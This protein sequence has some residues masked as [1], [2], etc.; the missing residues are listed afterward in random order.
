[1]TW[2]TR[3][4][5]IYLFWLSK[6]HELQRKCIIY[7]S[8]R[9]SSYSQ[10][11]QMA[12]L[13][14]I[15]VSMD[16]ASHKFTS[17]KFVHGLRNIYL[18]CFKATEGEERKEMTIRGKRVRNKRERMEGCKCKTEMNKDVQVPKS[19]DKKEIIFQEKQFL[20]TL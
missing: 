18:N 6:A 12:L 17:R 16:N 14:S 4:V 15:E 19:E 11:P 7:C 3:P 13:F 10:C 8:Y 20:F 9:G 1:M 2:N 5:S